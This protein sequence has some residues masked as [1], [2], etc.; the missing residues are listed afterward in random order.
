MRKEFLFRKLAP[1]ILFLIPAAVT[2]SGTYLLV[3]QVELD[4]A[5]A[6]AARYEWAASTLAGIMADAE[7][8]LKQPVKLPDRGGQWSHWYA[9]KKDGAELVTDSPVAHR[10]PRCGTVYTGYPYDE[11]VI[12]WEHLNHASRARQCGLAYR[13][14][15]RKEFAARAGEILTAYAGR[16]RTYPRHDQW[17]RDIPWGGRV[18]A[19]TLEESQFLISM[20]WAYALVRET[21]DAPARR[22]IEQ[23]LLRA[24]ANVILDHDMKIHNIQ[25]WKN[26]AVA[27]AGFVLNDPD[28]VH[29]A[30]DNPEHGFRA[31]IAKGVTGDGLWYEGST[32]YHY[33]TMSALWVLV[34]AARHAGINLYGERYRMLFDSPVRLAFPNGY[35]PAFNDSHSSDITARGDLYELAYT[36]WKRPLYAH[37]LAAGKRGSLQSL[38][39][40]EPVVE[41][42]PIIAEQSTLFR[43]AGVAM[44]RRQGTAAAVRFGL[45]GGGHGHPDK[46]NLLTFSGGEQFGVDPGSIAYGMPLQQEWFK[47]TVAHNT[48]SVDGA[49][50]EAVD[51]EFGSWSDTPD[52]VTLAA[53]ATRVCPGVELA[54]TVRLTPRRITDRFECTAAAEHTYDW[55]FHAYGTLATSLPMKPLLEKLGAA[56]GYQHITGVLHANT[57]QDWWAEWDVNGVR[58]RIRMR[59]QPGTEVFRGTAP[60]V[61]AREQV[62]LILV[63]RRARA[64]VFQAEH[65]F[66]R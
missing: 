16:Y 29:N 39:Y 1:A 37:L 11:V 44:L 20:S 48:V 26:S 7:A 3:D 2:G 18:S 28:L 50:Q 47:T 19:Q 8:A 35:T 9:C 49:Q 21:L 5:R 40:G 61:D 14:T 33:Y 38:L 34:E 56:N 17:G 42:G 60:G 64:T 30:I 41:S 51:G 24:A 45:H 63:R 31:Q 58:C 54:R 22:H 25:C 53:R 52:A 66:T 12:G 10:C 65:E 43:Q 62:A 59:G 13:F 46:L 4:A 15:G 27:A 55:V 6:K 32:S 57:D 36:R 23:D